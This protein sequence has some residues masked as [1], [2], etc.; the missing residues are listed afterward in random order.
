[1]API[2]DPSPCS[3]Y[4]GTSVSRT[5]VEPE[6]NGYDDLHHAFTDSNY[7][8][9][10]TAG[11]VTTAL[12]YWKPTNVTGWPAGNF[13]EPANSVHGRHTTYWKSSDTGTSSDTS[14]G[15]ATTGR[16]YLMYIAEYV[17]PPTWAYPGEVTFNKSTVFGTL[18]D[19]RDAL[20]WE[21][22]GHASN[23]ASYFYAWVKV[24]SLTDALLNSYIRWDV[25][26]AHAPV[27]VFV[28]T[29]YLP[30]WTR[31]GLAHAI[32]VYGFDDAADT[33]SYL[34]TCSVHCG[35][36]SNGGVHTINQTTLYNGIRA[37]DAALGA[38]S[39]GIDW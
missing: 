6:G 26:T 10:C 5:I 3:Y 19:S 13:T 8:N 37:V 32:T 20:N 14:N 28:M 27:V 39:G 22:S 24:S 9:F 25:Y 15:Y 29:D 23:W 1:L 38:G 12:D 17:Q 21:A 31:T 30:N 35:S 16:A 33:Y 36:S 11:A 4:L 34:D 18:P 2:C 7:W